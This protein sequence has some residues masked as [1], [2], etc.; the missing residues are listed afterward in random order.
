MKKI[1]FIITLVVS[2]SALSDY[3]GYDEIVNKLSAYSK[4]DLRD[5]QAYRSEI[6]T[7]SKVHLGLGL[8]QTFFDADAAGFDSRMQNQ[9]GLLI[10]VGV[11]VLNQNW[12]IEGSYSNFGTANNNNS[13]I[14]L[15]EFSLKGLYKPS[16]NKT[17]SMRM[18]L[19][20]SSRFLDISNPTTNESYKTPSALFLFGVESYISQM[21]SV[22]TDLGFKAAMIDDTIDKNSVD[23]SFRIDTHF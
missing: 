19:G 21:I 16:I 20:I 18:G 22:G 2:A 4:K 3:E 1:L 12:G 15:K 7:Y 17:W 9:G 11:D 10:N 5:N 8:S 6:R 23:L 13:Q 14:Q